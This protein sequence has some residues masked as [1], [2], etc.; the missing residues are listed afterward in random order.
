[1]LPPVR[2]PDWPGGLL[3]LLA[4]VMAGTSA[5]VRVA[6]A[7]T[8]PR[9]PGSLT[10]TRDIAP[11]VFQ[12]CA[13]C[14]RPGASGPF[15]LLTFSDAK[16]RAKQI[17]EVTASRQM[18]PWL[19][20]QGRGELVGARVLSADQ[21]GLIQQ[22]VAEGAIEGTATDLPALP[23]WTDGWHLGTPDVI[24]KLTNAYTLGADGRDVYRMFV[25]PIPTTARRFVRGV[26]LH[27]GSKTVH[28][29]FL[30]IDRTKQSRRLDEED[31]GPGFTAMNPPVSA[32][33]PGG[34]FLGWQPGRLPTFVPE[35]LA[36]TLEP[37]SDLVVQMH[38]QPS[39][40]PEQV[41]PE[42]GFYFTDRAPTNTPFKVGLSSFDIDIPAGA[43]NYVIRDEYTLPIDAEVLA[44]LPHAHYLGK[45]LQGF[46]TL[47]DGTTKS[48]LRIRQWDFNWQGD[49]RFVTPIFLPKGTRLA[50]QFSYDN[51]AGNPRNPSQPPKPVKYGVQST[52]EMGELWLQLL[53]RNTND[54]ET[55]SQDYGIKV[56]RE[57]VAY[58]Q[59]LL[60]SNPN[61]ARAHNHLGVALMS[62]RHTAEALQHFRAAARLQPEYDEAHYHLGVV[63][64]MQGKL[65]NAR[66]EFERAIACNPDYFKAYNNLANIFLAMQNLAEAEKH[67][68]AALR[69]NPEDP[70]AQSNLDA[71]L[72]AK[73]G[74]K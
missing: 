66:L 9:P 64:Q 53:A 28:H 57:V 44:V 31:D 8:A 42:V 70:I 30:R 22:W 32:I 62:Q 67:L 7:A 16:K 65:P 51:S 14:H 21:I 37:G 10:F 56:A 58:N 23:K 12:E 3:P 52:D 49:Y 59:Y 33:T 18:P 68:R 55:A 19:P 40:K 15:S 45:D 24:V 74:G 27:P 38:L 4:V 20:D 2:R 35:G 63:Y 39:G 1:M 50:L 25:L 48:L 13:G 60:R 17:A 73:S 5:P 34:H 47:P 11:I 72:K 54:L 6:E 69:I 43:T 29:A 46:A 26:E 36:W 71:V 41:Q 61:D